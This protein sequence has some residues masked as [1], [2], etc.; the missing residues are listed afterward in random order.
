MGAR[1]LDTEAFSAALLDRLAAGSRASR[2]TN[3]GVP[4]RAAG[5]RVACDLPPS[6]CQFPV[7]KVPG[8]R[9]FGFPLG[10]WPASKRI[11]GATAGVEEAGEGET[12]PW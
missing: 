8:S 7:R 9:T 1:E 4:Y 12:P 5:G 10:V 3:G 6:S 2:A 11:P